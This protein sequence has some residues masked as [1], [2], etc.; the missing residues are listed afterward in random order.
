MIQA[1]EG[2]RTLVISLEK[3]NNNHY[4]TPAIFRGAGTRTRTKSSQR[5]RAT[6]ALH[7]DYKSISL[8]FLEVNLC[9]TSTMTLRKICEQLNIKAQCRK[10]GLSLWQ[11]PQFLFVLMGIIIMIVIIVSF[12]ISSRRIEDPRLAVLI[13]LSLSAVLVIIDYIIVRSFE[14]LAEVAR[15]KMEFISVITHQLRSPITNIKYSLEILDSEKLTEKDREEYFRILKENT[16]RTGNLVNNI[17]TV[18][19]ISLGT[20][21]LRKEK[22]SIIDLIEE[23]ILEFR[24]LLR[25]SNITLEFEKEKELPK[26]FSDPFWLKEV[27]RNLLDNAI[28]YQKNRG[29]IGLMLRRQ[30]ENIYFQISDSGVGIPKEDQKYIF[31]KFFRVRNT[32]RYQT[33]GAGLGLYIVKEIIRKMKGKID[34]KS[35]ENKGTTFWFTLPIK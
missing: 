1:G 30:G 19:R 16:E 27:F 35:K 22:I 26:I 9:Y 5:T 29:D 33:T 24:P 15:A 34:F 7:P 6:I 23:T 31:Q 13:T 25:A 28:R 18:S 10:Y 32:L 2:N 20:F 8:F 4:T 11:C 14:K 21:K 12:L 3:R 17:L